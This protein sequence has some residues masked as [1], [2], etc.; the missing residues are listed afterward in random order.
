MKGTDNMP[1]VFDVADVQYFSNDAC[2]I[3]VTGR[4]QRIFLIANGSARFY[5]PPAMDQLEKGELYVLPPG[6]DEGLIEP[7]TNSASIYCVVF[8]SARAFR[9]GDQ[10]QIADTPLPLQGRI[11]VHPCSIILHRMKELYHCFRKSSDKSALLQLSFMEFLQAFLSSLSRSAGQPDPG[12]HLRHVLEHMDKHFAEP[13]QVEKIARASGMTPSVF[14]H[15]FKKHTSLSPQQYITQ[16]RIDKA[17]QLLATEDVKV[18]DVAQIVGYQDVGYFS[19]TF[20]KTTGVAPV[21]YAKSLRRRIAV[22][23][24]TIW[25]NLLALKVPAESLVPFWNQHDQKSPYMRIRAEGF[26][27]NRL[28]KIRPDMIIGTN[29][30]TLWLEYFAEI[31]PARLLTLKP[32]SWRDHLMEIAAI[33]GIEEVAERW[34]IQFDQ[35]VAAAQERIFQKIRYETVLAAR[36]S[37]DGIRVFGANRRKIGKFLYG[38][39]Q[40]NAPADTYRFSF[41]DL[42]T[43]KE[44]N[45]FQ[46]DHILLFHDGCQSGYDEA[47]L[48]GNVHH[49]KVYPW[50]HYSALGHEHMLS[51]ALAHFSD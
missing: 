18:G 7:M 35:K 21:H 16:K 40:M 9:E 26:D 25:E 29:K 32:A 5:F 50:F 8:S 27:L 31:A 10:W 48:N 12:A 20:K 3:P 6:S 42:G 19:R 17:C 47:S 49:T 36:V 2:I 33:I 38:D 37:K 4:E 45:G 13:F 46:A 41:T 11:H 51:E 30:D 34:L 14:Y 15:K 23:H 1:N 39:L 43:L 44:L 28:R 24:P 22:L